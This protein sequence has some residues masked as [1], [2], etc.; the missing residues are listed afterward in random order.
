MGLQKLR[1]DV[2]GQQH[3]NGAI[4]WYANWIG[5][6]S[7][8][9]VRNCPI[10]NTVIDDGVSPRTVYIQ[11]EADTF[12]SIPAACR[13]KG[14]TLRGYLTLDQDQCYE[15]RCYKNQGV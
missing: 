7:L 8:A 3:K 14:K 15:F 9:L 10:R 2:K 11:G 1:A 4:P 13:Y 12:F 6:V 5:G